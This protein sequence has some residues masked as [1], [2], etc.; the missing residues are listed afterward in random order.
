MGLF[1]V[2]ASW[3]LQVG[4]GTA[5]TG[6]FATAAD[7]PGFT[8]AHRVW[9]SAW[10]LVLIA[11]ANSVIAVLISSMNAATRMWYRMA[12]VGVLPSWLS[13]VHPRFKTPSNAIIAQ[14][15]LSLVLAFVLSA[16]WGVSNVFSVLGFL[17]IFGAIPAYIVANYS[18]F[19][20]YW[21][22]HRPEFNLFLHVIVPIIGTVGLLWFGYKSVVPLPPSPNS[23]AVPLTIRWFVVGVAIVLW[24]RARGKER[25]LHE[26]AGLAFD[27]TAPVSE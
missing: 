7:N 10:V 5:H 9:G 20:L 3:G 21:T 24:L 1:L 18:V 4:W 16:A 6:S 26:K 13:Y 15:V 11:L 8:I 14:T 12:R 25:E 17:F 19:R 27:E 23:W 22:E 2:F